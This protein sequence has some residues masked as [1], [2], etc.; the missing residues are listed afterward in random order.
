[1]VGQILITM[2]TVI[3]S[4]QLWHSS[5]PLSKLVTCHCRKSLFHWY[6]LPAS[7]YYYYTTEEVCAMVFGKAVKEE[8]NP[9]ILMACTC[10]SD[11][12]FMNDFPQT[13]IIPVWFHFGRYQ[14]FKV[15]SPTR[16]KTWSNLKHDIFEQLVLPNVYIFLILLRCLFSVMQ[17][18]FA[19]AEI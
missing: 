15:A 3:F 19:K 9:I 12:F 11:K 14:R 6:S 2:T 5:T 17:M 1:M 13:A 18:D 7:L 8:T 16:V 4:K 10:D